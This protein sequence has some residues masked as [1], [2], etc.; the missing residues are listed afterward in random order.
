MERKFGDVWGA[1]VMDGAVREEMVGKRE[2]ER[3]WGEMEPVERRW[4]LGGIGGERR[5]DDR[6][7]V[8]GGGGGSEA[9]TSH[10]P[11]IH[12]T[13]TSPAGRCEQVQVQ[14]KR[15]ARHGWFRKAGV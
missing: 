5:C 4:E 6:R 1:G 7:R 14:G 15:K 2:M 12:F 9:K 3:D 8:V 13:A 10:S 11:P